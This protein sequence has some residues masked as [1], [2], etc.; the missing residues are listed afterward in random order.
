[1]NSISKKHYGFQHESKKII[2]FNIIFFGTIM[3]N[4]NKVVML[5]QNSQITTCEECLS[6]SILFLNKKWLVRKHY[7]KNSSQNIL[8]NNTPFKSPKKIIFL[9]YLEKNIINI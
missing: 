6:I 4:M 3:R 9:L 8:S 1:M 5:R 7:S 2:D